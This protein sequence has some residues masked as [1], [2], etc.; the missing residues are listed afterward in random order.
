MADEN[1]TGGELSEYVTFTVTAKD[2]REVEMAVVDEFE[3]ERK[4]YV[5]SALIENETVQEENLYI[6]RLVLKAGDDFSVE[7]I[8]D[9]K[10]YQRVAEAYLE[11]E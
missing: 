5:A 3:F 9:P 11:M 4:N 1:M 6:Y 8:T 7:K 2:G 10:E